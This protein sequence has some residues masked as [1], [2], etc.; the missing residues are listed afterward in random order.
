MGRRG[1]SAPTHVGSP[2][3]LLGLPGVDPDTQ[4]VALPV[5]GS[6][7]AEPQEERGPR[8]DSPEPVAADL[9]HRRGPLG[10]LLLIAP[11]RRG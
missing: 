1:S 8:I 3:I 10:Q 9:E 7:T 2:S 5:N 11:L 4:P 6:V